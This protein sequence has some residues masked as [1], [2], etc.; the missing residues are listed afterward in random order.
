MRVLLISYEYPPDTGRGGIGT[1]MYQLST[2]LANRQIETVVICAT[3]KEN[4]TS[5]VNEQLTVVRIQTNN[6]ESFRK[7]VPVVAVELHEKKKFSIIECPEFGA[8]ALYLKKYFPATP[9]VIKLHSPRFLIKEIND[10]YYDQLLWRRIKKA[11]RFLYNYKKDPEYQA[12]LHADHITSPSQSLK[13]IIVERWHLPESKITVIPNPYTP[14]E[15]FLTIKNTAAANTVLYVGRLETRKGVYNLAKAIP[16]VLKKFPAARFIFLGNDSR[17]PLREKSMKA[18]LQKVVAPYQHQIHFI[19]SV[20]IEEVPEYLSNATCC[21]F[22]SIWENF[23][24][25]CLEAMAAGKT[26]VASEAGGMVDMLADSD[27]TQLVN[28]HDIEAIAAGIINCLTK[29][30]N[31]NLNL[32]NREKVIREYGEKVI[33]TTISLYQSLIL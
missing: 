31:E 5:V 21:V 26:I 4:Y 25:V 28:P 17:G 16:M 6:T 12:I 23:P 15:D 20:P 32:P 14:T 1:Y 9:I 11:L 7:L 3:N 22:P 10:H 27:A 2:A 29:K 18:V 19:N 33:D 30:Q 8:E 24:N 13:D